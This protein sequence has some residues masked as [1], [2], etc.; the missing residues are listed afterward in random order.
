MD[1][2]VENRFRYHAPN[3]EARDRHTRLSDLFIDLTHEVIKL[4]PYSREL[5]IV[6]TKLEEA[7]F[8]ASSGVARNQYM[9]ESE[10]SSTGRA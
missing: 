3:N 4:V 1:I 5:N 7:K 8:W 2:D 10:T 9:F 6:L